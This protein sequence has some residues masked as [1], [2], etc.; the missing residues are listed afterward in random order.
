M[1]DEERKEGDITDP[2]TGTVVG[3]SCPD[4]GRAMD[5]SVV[6]KDCATAARRAASSAQRTS[7]KKDE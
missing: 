2:T 3:H 5:K 7:S 4:C 6:C 1:A